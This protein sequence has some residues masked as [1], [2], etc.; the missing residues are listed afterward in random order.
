M[1]KTTEERY[2]DILDQVI[3]VCTPFYS[4]REAKVLGRYE[5][6]RVLLEVLQ[7]VLDRLDPAMLEH[8]IRELR[9][10]FVRACTALEAEQAAHV[11]PPFAIVLPPVTDTGW[12]NFPDGSAIC[13]E[14]DAQ[15]VRWVA[16][17]PERVTLTGV[18]HYPEV[19]DTPLHA[20]AALASREL[21]PGAVVLTAEQRQL[22][23]TLQV[24]SFSVRG[25]LSTQIMRYDVRAR[26]L[27]AAVNDLR[28]T[29][30][31]LETIALQFEHGHTAAQRA[32]AAA[33]A[34]Y[35]PPEPSVPPEAV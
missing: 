29:A 30:R 20:A 21:G 3:A 35:T 28:H 18:D 13:P 1:T 15:R 32:T 26:A 19:F 23:A 33:L 9:E 34:A 6:P 2:G 31:Q 22:W 27:R 7:T 17:T 10:Y 8:E 25:L 11:E 24:E 4:L 16:L 5:L 12:Y 14:K